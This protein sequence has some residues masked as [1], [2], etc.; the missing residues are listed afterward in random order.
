[1][2]FLYF[3]CLLAPPPSSSSIGD[4]VGDEDGEGSSGGRN[5]GNDSVINGIQRRYSLG[6]WHI[7]LL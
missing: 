3:I 6:F 7:D 5:H 4:E 1:M 2:P